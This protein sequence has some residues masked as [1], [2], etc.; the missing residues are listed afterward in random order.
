MRTGI[1]DTPTQMCVYEIVD[2][3]DIG[4][5]DQLCQKSHSL[6]N[7]ARKLGLLPRLALEAGLKPT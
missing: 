6:F 4:P 2:G 5:H 3:A 7:R 1:A